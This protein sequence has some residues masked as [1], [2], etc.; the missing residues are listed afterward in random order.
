MLVPAVSS[1]PSW[2]QIVGFYVSSA[3]TGQLWFFAMEDMNTVAGCASWGTSGTL[4][5]MGMLRPRYRFE[6]FLC[7]AY[8]VTQSLFL[9]PNSSVYGT[10]MS[11]LFGWSMASCGYF[12]ERKQPGIIY[13]G[14]SND[15][16]GMKSITF[17]GTAGMVLLVSL[18]VLFM[19]FKS[20]KASY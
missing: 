4:C 1:F 19:A 17:M 7:A 9:R 20:N 2:Y 16:R 11:A 3:V 8:L 13:V 18:P 12:V 10:T 15:L 5:M 14:N 6:L